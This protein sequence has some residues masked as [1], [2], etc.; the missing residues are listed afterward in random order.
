MSFLSRVKLSRILHILPKFLFLFFIL[1]NLIIIMGEN[2]LELWMSL[3]EILKLKRC[4]L[5][6]A[7]FIV[8]SWFT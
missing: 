7:E 6:F 4:Q 1:Y 8:M 5:F 3:Q 2:E